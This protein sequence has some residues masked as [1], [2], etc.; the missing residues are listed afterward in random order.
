MGFIDCERTEETFW[1]CGNIF[2]LDQATLKYIKF[3]Q[4]VHL[5]F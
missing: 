3:H 2:Y 5:R 1:S 4:A